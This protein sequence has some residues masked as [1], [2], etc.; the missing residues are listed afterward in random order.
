M[1]LQIYYF[2]LYKLSYIFLTLASYQIQPAYNVVRESMN[3][4]F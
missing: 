1:Q 3:L 2:I 4:S